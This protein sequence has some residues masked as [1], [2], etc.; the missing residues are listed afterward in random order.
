MAPLALT[1]GFVLAALAADA[2]G[3]HG[4]GFY[5]LLVAVPAAAH[6]ALS[7]FGDLVELP[8]GAPGLVRARLRTAFSALALTLVLLTAVAR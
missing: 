6:A 5:L 8:A 7:C 2:D 4:I 1:A 3:H